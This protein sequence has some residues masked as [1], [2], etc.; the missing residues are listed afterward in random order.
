MGRPALVAEVGQEPAE[1]IEFLR[2]EI[3]QL[4]ANPRFQ[5][6]LSGYLLP[7]AISQS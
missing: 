1:L 3:G 5:D 4:T 7:D 6:A 2:E